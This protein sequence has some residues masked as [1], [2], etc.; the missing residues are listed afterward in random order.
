MKPEDKDWRDE[1]MKILEEYIEKTR[2]EYFYISLRWVNKAEM[3]F[4]KIFWL[5]YI[6]F[7][8]LALII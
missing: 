8:S 6:K 2:R 5:A 4:F 7:S 1:E 3:D